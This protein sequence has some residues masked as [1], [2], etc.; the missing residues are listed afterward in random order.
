[1]RT[2]RIDRDGLA[3]RLRW[4]ATWGLRYGAV[5]TI[6]A[7]LAV[8]LGGTRLLDRAG[9]S[10]LGV[11]LL[12]LAGGPLIGALIGLLRPVADTD[13]G[14]IVV[15]I[16]ATVPL[17][18]GVALAKGEFPPWSPDTPRRRSPPRSRSRRRA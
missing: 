5:Y 3:S 18:A 14:A 8:V 11:L 15:G 4:G 7:L 12:Y 13:L 9:V 17:M 6:V 1:M 16:V 2:D 10:L